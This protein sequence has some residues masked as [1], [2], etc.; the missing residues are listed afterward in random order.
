[1]KEKF[2]EEEHSEE[3]L[4]YEKGIAFIGEPFGTNKKE[5][6]FCKNEEKVVLAENIE[7]AYEDLK[8]TLDIYRDK[9]INKQ[10]RDNKAGEHKGY[11]DFEKAEKTGMIPIWYQLNGKKVLL[12]LGAVG[13]T[14]YEKRLNDLVGG[15]VP[16]T[17]RKNLCEACALFGMAKDEAVGGRIRFTDAKAINLEKIEKKMKRKVLLRIL[18]QPRYSYLPFYAK[19]PKGKVPRSYDEDGVEIAGRKFY[20]HNKEAEYNDKIYTES[21]GMQNQNMSSRMDLVMP[22]AE[23]EFEVY[24]DGITKEQLSKFIWV[25]NL[26]ENEKQSNLCHKIGHGKPLGLGSI[27]ITIDEKWKREYGRDIY[28]WKEI[29]DEEIDTDL[30]RNLKHVQELKKVLNFEEPKK[31][32]QVSIEYPDV[33]DENDRRFTGERN[34]DVQRHQ[35]YLAN[36]RGRGALP[37]IGDEQNIPA[38]KLKKNSGDKRERQAEDNLK[39]KR[40]QNK[41][42]QKKAKNSHMR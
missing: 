2:S 22:G 30:E 19:G 23:F 7:K 35:W 34:N 27:K 17:S 28:E 1:M 32:D 9:G 6:I 39:I 41:K 4:S 16:C 24:F 10:Y 15:K 26:G 33:C 31:A 36:R 14:V 37:K 40:Y 25:L 11:P 29:K 38:Y 20:W 8:K 5:G 21:E 18:G 3:E 42:G 12:S 13:R